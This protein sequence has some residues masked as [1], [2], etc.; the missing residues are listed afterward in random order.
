MTHPE[1]A[2]AR[3]GY[4]GRGYRIPG[5][6]D[7]HGKPIVYPSVTTVLNHVAKP[8]LQQ[9]IA[10]ETAAFAV[11]NLNYL[12]A[13]REDVGYGFLRFYWAR[14]P[15]LDATDLRL[16]HEIVK[17]DAAELGTNL[18]EHIQADIDGNLP[19]PPV[20]SEAVLEM[21]AVW[22]E[23]FAQHE[24]VSH[25]QEFTVVHRELRYAGTADADWSIRCLHAE[26]CFGT[27]EWVRCLIDLK[28]SR[29]TWPEHGMQLAAL[30]NAPILM[31]WEAAGTPGA[32]KAEKQENGVKRVSWWTEHP[33]TEY[34]RYALLHIRPND[35]DPTG[36]RIPAFI[37]MIDQTA[38]MDEHWE[39][40]KGALSLAH[41]QYRLRRRQQARGFISMEGAA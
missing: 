1:L 26:P 21:L 24:I 20:H 29:Y 6:R 2:S 11:T 25:K 32:R 41:S 5:H 7:E 22:E 4:G 12:L 17:N 10:D 14:S 28:S 37:E 30:A 39:S 13:H 38:D 16:R 31:R 3:S 8:G 19:Y 27:R 34:D 40:F 18:H 35:L 33:R 23:W 15:D 36:D 9:W